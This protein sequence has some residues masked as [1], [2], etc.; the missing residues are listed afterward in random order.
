[1][2]RIAQFVSMLALAATLVPPCLFFAD[3]LDLAGTQQWLLAAA[4]LWFVT[5]PLWMEHTAS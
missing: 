4:V 2:K 1:M 5:T 3:R